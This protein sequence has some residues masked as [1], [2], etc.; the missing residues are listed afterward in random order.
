MCTFDVPV[1]RRC[2]DCESNA[3]ECR[4][5]HCVQADGVQRTMLSVNKKLPGTAVQVNPFT[6]DIA[7][8]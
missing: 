3:T 4:E 7:C 5:R 1:Y 2:S 6:C 8:F